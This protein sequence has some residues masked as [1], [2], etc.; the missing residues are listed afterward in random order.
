MLRE[1]FSHSRILSYCLAGLPFH[2]GMDESFK[3]K[4]KEIWIHVEKALGGIF[5]VYDYY[6]ITI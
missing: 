3:R 2:E 5:G 6:F 1:T 4:K